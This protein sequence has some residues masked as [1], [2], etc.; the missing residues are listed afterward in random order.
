[1]Y[2]GNGMQPEHVQQKAVDV[3]LEFHLMRSHGQK[4]TLLEV[5]QILDQIADA[6]A[7][8]AP[9]GANH[10]RFLA[11]SNPTRRRVAHHALPPS[12]DRWSTMST[13]K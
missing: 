13:Q 1:M 2:P 11:S 12:D 7:R 10:G 9:N 4:C 8:L 6:V 5:V 3:G